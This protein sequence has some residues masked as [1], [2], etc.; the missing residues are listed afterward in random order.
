MVMDFHATGP[1]HKS[2][3]YLLIQVEC[4]FEVVC[5]QPETAIL[6][7]GLIKSFNGKFGVCGAAHALQS[8]KR[9]AFLRICP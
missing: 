5:L 4:V 8:P 9:T 7:V 2:R 1:D 3:V 6:P